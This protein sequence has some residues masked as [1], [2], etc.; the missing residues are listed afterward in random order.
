MSEP[1]ASSVIKL[2]HALNAVPTRLIQSPPTQSRRA[3]VAII[4]RFRPATRFVFQGAE[5]AGYNGSAAILRDQWGEGYQLEDFMRLPWVN[6][7]ETIPEVLFIRRASPL[8]SAS[9][10]SA[11]THHRWA[12]HIAFP[13]GRQEP[14]DQSA[15]YTALRETWEEIGLDLAEKEFLN[16]GR[17]DEREVTTSLGKRLLMIL[18][19]F[20]FLQTSP[21]TPKPEIQANEI[22]SIHWISLSLLT[23][24]FSPSR[25]SQVDID[26]S[27]RL[28]PKNKLIRWCLRNLIGKMKFGC[29]L[30][31]DEPWATAENF[32]RS[33][34]NENLEGSGSWTNQADGSRV[35]RLWGLTLGMTLDLISHLPS[36]PSKVF[37]SD[38]EPLSSKLGLSNV[39]PSPCS[40]PRTPVTVHSSF[41]DQ[42]ETAKK[43]LDE[44]KLKG[45]GLKL[46]IKGKRPGI[47]PYMT[48]VFP[49]FTYPDVNF[50]IYV[51]SRRYCQVIRSWELSMQQHPPRISDRRINWSGQ[52]LATF[53]SAVRQALIVAIALRAFCVGSGVI[54][55][56]W[57]ITKLL[58]GRKV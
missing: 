25:W 37:L 47:G 17:L 15:Y 12:S 41:E 9:S 43:A 4:I 54:G 20:V 55:A 21:F 10:P 28:S 14:D 46:K 42:W 18:S 27:T 38:P 39:E 24:P 44:S 40:I 1:A 8:S 45:S 29:L 57:W 50:W 35:L 2:F 13:G 33:N 11:S 6:D 16:V 31:P 30:L 23:P 36:A 56:G 58:G 52:A 51:F 32:D 7:P 5:P 34:F 22:S 49:T 19:P 3:S 26:I 53:Y 48:A